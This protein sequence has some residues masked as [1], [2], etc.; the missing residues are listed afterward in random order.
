MQFFAKHDLN[1]WKIVAEFRQ[2]EFA[3]AAIT[4]LSL[5]TDAVEL[6]SG[7]NNGKMSAGSGMGRAAEGRLAA[8]LVSRDRNDP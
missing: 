8:G 6:I 5:S 3:Q 7:T 4:S 2:L 1:I